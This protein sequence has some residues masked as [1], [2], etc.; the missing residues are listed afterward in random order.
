MPE[1]FE[2]QQRLGTIEALLA[3]IDSSADPNLRSTVQELVEL[4]MS[5]QGAGL[6]RMLELIQANGEAGES[7]IKKLGSDELTSSLLILYGLHPLTVQGR[8]ERALDKLRSRLR[9]LSAEVELVNATEGAIRLRIRAE[10]HGCGSSAQAVKELVE[11]AVYGAA[12]DLASL[13]IEGAEEKQSFIS[14]DTLALSSA[15]KGGL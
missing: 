12:P 13:V 10:G 5:L 8:V 7:I 4:I 6:E 9:P 1:T 3:T 11:E 2:L 15:G 14:I